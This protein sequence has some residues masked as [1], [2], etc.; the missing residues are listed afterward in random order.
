MAGVDSYAID[1]PP[2]PVSRPRAVWAHFIRGRHT[3]FKATRIGRDR[4][5]RRRFVT[6]MTRG[7][8]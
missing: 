5:A 4:A 8:R 2:R 1:W 3:T 7:E 6:Q